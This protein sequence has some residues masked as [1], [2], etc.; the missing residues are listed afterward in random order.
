MWEKGRI[1]RKIWVWNVGEVEN[2]QKDMNVGGGRR[3]E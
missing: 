2:K 1:K 3:G